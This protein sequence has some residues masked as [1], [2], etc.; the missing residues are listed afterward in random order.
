MRN[1]DTL[2]FGW[3]ALTGYPARTWLTLLAMAIGVAAVVL[4]TALGEGARRY[5][6]QEFSNLGTHLLI[7]LPGRNETTGGPP[8]L[9][10]ATPRDLT[11]DDALSL[12]RNPRVDRVAP[13]SV[14][15]AP[16]SHGALDRETSIVG[17]TAEL[18]P[19]R[20]LDLAHGRF[21]PLGDA[22]RAR[23]LVVLG[24]TLKQEL[25]GNE[26]ALGRWVRIGDRRFRVIGVLARRG[27]S[28]GLDMSEVAIVPVASAQSLFDNPAL[29]RILVQAH[30]HTGL[31]PAKQAILSTIR[32]RHEGED[33]ITVI[34][35]DALLG[36]FEGILRALTYAVAGIGAIS[37]LVAGVLIMNVM[38]VS[39][40][41]RTREIGLLKALG[42][43]RAQILRLFLA[44]AAMLAGMGAA[45]G[46][47]LSVAGLWLLQGLFPAFPMT[48]PAWAP[49]TAVAVSVG[50]GLLFGLQPA[51]RAARLDPVAALSGH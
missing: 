43:A 46:L 24:S 45:A 25:F 5:V 41:Q 48:P 12:T 11:L 3:R 47:V 34:T 35:Q 17:S 16:V 44:E 22:Q 29:F 32:E 26:R 18:L 19:V 49:P 31:E 7:V 13:I 38:L 39:V 28:L 14:G 9:M 51:R 37:L 23:P 20:R 27:Q 50:T 10:G 2:A 36:T 15:S 30:S 21:L 1:P 4:L 6:V 8:P 40:A 33:D 42:A